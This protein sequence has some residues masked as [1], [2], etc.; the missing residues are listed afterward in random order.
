[1]T[2]AFK[3]QLFSVWYGTTGDGFDGLS[4]AWT[5]KYTNRFRYHFSPSPCIS[6]YKRAL[7]R[8][9]EPNLHGWTN[10][11][12]NSELL[13]FLVSDFHCSF[14]SLKCMVYFFP[15]CPIHGF[16]GNVSSSLNTYTICSLDLLPVFTN[17]YFPFAH[18]WNIH[19]DS[20]EL[21]KFHAP[22]A[23]RPSTHTQA[24]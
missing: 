15:D 23:L 8:Q 16:L 19:R 6:R 18:L 22:S 20:N 5:M 9:L 7:E 12:H 24:H 1:M 3:K 21:L 14:P 10:I 2:S 11:F 4:Y 17:L 13:S